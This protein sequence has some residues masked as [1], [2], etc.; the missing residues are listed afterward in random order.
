MLS[1]EPINDY[2][3]LR[4]VF[5]ISL[6]FFF[7][8][9]F[10]FFRALLSS[11]IRTFGKI[12]IMGCFFLWKQCLFRYLRKL[13]TPTEKLLQVISDCSFLCILEENEIKKGISYLRNK[14]KEPSLKP[15]WNYMHRQWII[16]VSPRFWT[17]TGEKF[18]HIC[19]TNNP[20]ERFFFSFRDLDLD[21]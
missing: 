14:Y 2:L 5:L 15:F 10:F 7:L 20:L 13:R 18:S 9:E 19:F 4:K 17:M 8:I 3:R 12:P 6:L 21:H 1:V 16:K 11:L